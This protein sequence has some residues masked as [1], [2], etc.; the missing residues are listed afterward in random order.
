MAYAIIPQEEAIKNRPT[1]VLVDEK[2]NITKI[3]NY[4]ENGII[5]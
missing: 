2:K 1:I 5:S 3:G 4:K